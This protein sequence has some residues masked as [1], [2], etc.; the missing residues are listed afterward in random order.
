MRSFVPSFAVLAFL[1]ACGDPAGSVIDGRG[2]PGSRVAVLAGD[3]GDSGGASTAAVG[4][5][6]LDSGADLLP[7]AAPVIFEIA[8]PASV[9]AGQALE[10][11]WRVTAE[12]G[13]DTVSEQSGTWMFVRSPSG[14]VSWCAVP[15]HAALASGDGFDGTFVATCDLPADAPNDRYGVSIAAV[16]ARGQW[17]EVTEAGT[18]TVSGGSDDVAPPLPSDRTVTPSVAR[19]GDT[20]TVRFR[21]QDDAGVAYAV[22]WVFGTNGLITDPNGA[23]WVDYAPA[24]LVAGDGHDGTWEVA[25]PL[26]ADLPAGIYGLSFSLGDVVGNEVYDVSFPAEVTFEIAP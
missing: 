25:L 11:S 19:P 14:F 22:P 24:A 3:T 16:D 7:A 26:R 8:V 1:V 4:D 23:M 6:G 18:F 20:V 13:I 2:A 15:T 17:S 12:G 21:L 9:A 5:S 10:I